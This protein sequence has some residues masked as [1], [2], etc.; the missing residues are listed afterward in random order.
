LATARAGTTR[1]TA[2]T[3]LAAAS[4]MGST[5]LG[6]AAAKVDSVTMVIN[7]SPW[8]E[9]IRQLVDLYERQTGNHVEIDVNPFAGSLEKQR[10]SVR[11]NQGQ[12]DLL[13]MNSG[14]FAEMYFG[15]FVEPITNI[16]PGFKLDPEL[17]TLGDTIY[18]DAEKKTMTPQ[19]KLMALPFAPIIPMLYYRG[20]LYAS[21][22]LKAPETFAELEDNCRKFHKPP[23]MYGIV[24]RGARGPHTVAYDFY[25]YLYGFG[26]SIFKDQPSSDYSVTLNSEAGRTALDYYIRLARTVGHP[27]TAAFDQAEVLQNFLTGKAA[28]ILTVIAAWSQMDDPNKSA[29]VDKVEYAPPPHAPGFPTAPGL[30]HFVTGI[31]RNVPDG[32]KRGAL[33]FLRW[34]QQKDTQIALA[35]AGGMPVHA[36]AYRD[37][38]ADER[39]YRWMKPLA[40]ALPK[41]VN[42]YQFPESNEVIAILELGL[43]RAIAGES[44]SIEALNTMSAQ[45]YEVM[46]KH[47]YKTAKL[48]PLR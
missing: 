46:S 25:P 16:D 1:R 2:L 3:A 28:H 29:I 17:Y 24:Q 21:A 27:K 7:Q 10:N 34:F 13:V 4:F 48:E 8:F 43:N 15:G 18:F 22:G 41:A 12:C 37:P 42:I 6:R 20:D 38:I 44:T 26:G 11:S 31:A 39:R 33:E 19:G 23:G 32:R 45:I 35:K 9:S 14:W 36:A 30:G 40:A 5:R 47:D